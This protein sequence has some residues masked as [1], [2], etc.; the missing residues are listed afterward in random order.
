MIKSK[1][2]NSPEE[3]S[4]CRLKGE[5]KDDKPRACNLGEARESRHRDGKKWEAHASQETIPRR[6]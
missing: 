4:E 3:A 5:E 1:K 6:A 2:G